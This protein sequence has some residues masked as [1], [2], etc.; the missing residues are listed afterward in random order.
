MQ[1]EKNNWKPVKSKTIISSINSVFK[2]NDIEKLSKTAYTFVMNLSGFI[3]HYDLHGF[4]YE[5]QNLNKFATNLQRICTEDE[6]KRLGQD[7]DFIEWYGKS[8]CQ[9]EADT[10]LGIKQIVDNWLK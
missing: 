7:L 9:S 1:Q 3:A 8:Y 4:R 5:Y 6:A 2:N 10:I